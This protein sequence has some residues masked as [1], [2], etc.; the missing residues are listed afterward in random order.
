MRL[1]QLSAGFQT[2]P[3]LPTSKLGPSGA[4]SQVGGFVYVPGPFVGLSNEL[5]CEAGSFSLSCNPHR[6]F[7]SE[8][9]RF[10]QWNPGLL[11]LSHSPVVP[12]GL[13]ACKCGSAWSASHCTASPCHPGCLSLPFLPVWMNVSSLTLW[14]SDFFNSLVVSSVFWKFWLFLVFKFVVVLLL[15]V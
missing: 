12:P 13:S 8:V 4:D 14:L 10:P 3:L 2:F 15:L 1:A 7:Q 5:F 11:S 6:F 9:L